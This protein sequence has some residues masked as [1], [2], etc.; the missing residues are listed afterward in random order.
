[1]SCVLIVAAEASMGLSL[2][3]AFQDLGYQVILTADTE[4]ALASIAN[5]RLSGAVVDI[6]LPWLQGEDLTRQLRKA[7]GAM[8]IVVSTVLGADE[9]ADDI[10][11]DPGIVIIEKPYTLTD[12]VDRFRNLK[13]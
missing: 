9:I 6:A 5:V 11:F 8:P 10:R 7:N 2:L 12:I 3:V 13:T 1:M 4:T